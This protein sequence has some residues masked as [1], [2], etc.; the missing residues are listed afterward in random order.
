MSSLSP[1]PKQDI[2]LPVIGA[3]PAVPVIK[4]SWNKFGEEGGTGGKTRNMKMR[5]KERVTQA[6]LKNSLVGGSLDGSVV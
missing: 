1:E 5:Q 2:R 4:Y 3:E 6:Y